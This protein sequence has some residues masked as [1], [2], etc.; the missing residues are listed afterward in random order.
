[1]NIIFMGTPD[2]AVPSFKALISNF[3]VRAVFTQPD[4]PKGRGKKLSMSPIKMVAIENN[5]EV[6]QPN[7]IKGNKEIIDKIKA[8]EPDFIIVVAFGQILP[9]EVLQ[10][11]RYGCVNL[12]ASLLPKYR[13]AAPI[14]WSIIN[15]EEMTGNTTML[16]DEGLDTG[17]MLL[18]STVLIDEEMTAG[19][20]HDILMEDGKDLL[21]NTIKGIINGNIKRIKQESSPTGYAS[22][23]NKKLALINWNDKSKNIINLIRGLNPWPVAYTTYND[24]TMKIYKGK[25]SKDNSKETPGTIVGISNDGIKVATLDNDIIIKEIQFP[26]KKS[27]TVEEYLR[28]NKLEKG[29]ILR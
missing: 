6:F 5:I 7:K 22:M 12:H 26:G 9:K 19:E 11:P 10:I 20:L 23:L 25:V 4:K 14:N 2:F 3:G 17:D 27:L 18:K 24:V 8:M 13:G 16:M 28:G 21:I 15:G 29:I 1:M